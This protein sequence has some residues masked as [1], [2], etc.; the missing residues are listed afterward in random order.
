MGPCS[1]HPPVGEPPVLHLADVEV[2]VA[3]KR[4]V[5][6]HRMGACSV[7]DEQRRPIGRWT[8]QRRSTP[9]LAQGAQAHAVVS[10]MRVGHTHARH[11]RCDVVL[12][13]ERRAN[14]V[15]VRRP[16]VLTGSGL[17][18]D[19]SRHPQGHDWR[20]LHLH[21]HLESLLHCAG[22]GTVA[23]LGMSIHINISMQ[24]VTTDR[25]R[26]RLTTFSGVPA[27]TASR[28]QES[29]MVNTPSS[30]PSKDWSWMRS[31]VWFAPHGPS[32]RHLSFVVQ[33]PHPLEP[34]RTFDLAVL[35]GSSR[36]VVP[37]PCHDDMG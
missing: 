30:P 6:H 23:N 26:H 21:H 3:G 27:I 34:S 25:P 33:P 15:M 35:H 8:L 24:E 32:R 16:P 31:Q 12:G 17:R 29:G 13:S 11:H 2:L 28:T 36:A 18:S 14:W 4:P 9:A 7:G 5:P 10:W 37:N 22:A 19:R 1:M 20:W